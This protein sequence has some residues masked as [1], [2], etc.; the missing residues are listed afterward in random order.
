MRKWKG[1][2]IKRGMCRGGF[3]VGLAMR[4]NEGKK[5]REKGR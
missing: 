4:G 3:W 2:R 1:V 5:E